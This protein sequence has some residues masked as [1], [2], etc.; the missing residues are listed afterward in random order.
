M[1]K[2]G[3]HS[4][5]NHCSTKPATET[6]S[7][8]AVTEETS[9][10]CVPSLFPVSQLIKDVHTETGISHLSRVASPLLSWFVFFALTGFSGEKGERGA[11]GIGTQGPRGPPGPA[12]KLIAVLPF[13]RPLWP[14][15]FTFYTPS[16][17]ATTF[18]PLKFLPRFWGFWNSCL[19]TG[20]IAL[21][22]SFFISEFLW[23]AREHIIYISDN[24]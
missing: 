10:P 7:C 3:L 9:G 24:L 4:C 8:K 15:T 17:F 16:L 20:V 12:G 2:R 14:V 23:W 11:T 22:I 21:T 1:K 13:C 19:S 5:I 18:S 6:A